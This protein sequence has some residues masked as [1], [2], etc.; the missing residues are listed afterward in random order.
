MY[1][2]P[3]L[4]CISPAYTLQCMRPEKNSYTRQC[5]GRVSPPVVHRPQHCSL[6]PH[7]KDHYQKIVNDSSLLLIASC[8]RQIN[9][10]Q[11]GR[12]S[13]NNKV[14]KFVWHM[15][16]MDHQSGSIYLCRNKQYPPFEANIPW[17]V[18]MRAKYNIA[19]QSP[20]ENKT[21]RHCCV[22]HPIRKMTSSTYAKYCTYKMGKQH[23]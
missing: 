6:T 17:P 22:T 8:W 7:W 9:N 20:E 4:G 21:T 13:N 12:K 15:E 10:K 11:Q 16:H 5:S 1:L 2:V 18:T 3:Y 19:Y 23:H 14:R